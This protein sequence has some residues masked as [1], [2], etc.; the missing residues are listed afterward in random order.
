MWGQ[1]E[2]AGETDSEASLKNEKI[3]E[4]QLF[5]K[6]CLDFEEYFLRKSNWI[7]ALGMVWLCV[8]S[9]WHQSELKGY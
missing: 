9:Q 1:G 4:N 5:K 2:G 7:K 3:N 6:P 8:T